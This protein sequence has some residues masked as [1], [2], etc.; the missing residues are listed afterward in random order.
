MNLMVF[1]FSNWTFKLLFFLL[2]CCDIFVNFTVKKV[3]WVFLLVELSRELWFNE[4]NFNF[5]QINWTIKFPTQTIAISSNDFQ[6][7]FPTLALFS[8]S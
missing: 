2:L 1:L 7:C 6:Q 3:D 4:G 5:N 8:T